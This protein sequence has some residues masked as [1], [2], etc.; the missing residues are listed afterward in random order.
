[1]K[2]DFFWKHLLKITKTKSRN[3]T[4][5]YN[6]SEKIIDSVKGDVIIFPHKKQAGNAFLKWIEL[7]DFSPIKIMGINGV[8]E[9]KIKDTD[10]SVRA[11]Y[12][13]LIINSDKV[14]KLAEL[15]DGTVIAASFAY[16]NGRVLLF[17]TGVSSL[18]GDMG[19]SGY[20]ADIIDSFISNIPIPPKPEKNIQEKIQK[21]NDKKYGEV[22]SMLS[23]DTILK[24]ASIV[25]LLELIVFIIK[26]LRARKAMLLIF[27]LL[28]TASAP[29]YAED[30]KF[31]ELTIDGQAVKYPD[32][33][34]NQT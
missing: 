1:M 9:S 7:F 10:I 2:T 28:I 12:P 29:L 25:F 15:E 21:D 6:P 31:I 19:V 8:K 13:I 33:P 18:W 16:N 20:F 23:F 5:I 22:K 3:V 26:F 27:V 11:C 4:I 17:G 14:K 32:V 34:D 24:I 30:F